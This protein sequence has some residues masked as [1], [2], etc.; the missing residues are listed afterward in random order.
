MNF[1]LVHHIL[2]GHSS[3][4]DYVVPSYLH[5][6]SD[7]DHWFLGLLTCMPTDWTLLLVG[8]HPAHPTH[9]SPVTFLSWGLTSLI[10]SLFASETV[11]GFSPSPRKTQIPWCGT[12]HHT[13]RD[14]APTYLAIFHQV[15]NP[16]TRTQ[17][18]VQK[19]P[20]VGMPWSSGNMPFCFTSWVWSI[21]F[22]LVPLFPRGDLQP[23]HKTHF[24]SCVVS[25]DFPRSQS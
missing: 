21:L 24:P 22:S 1:S 6:S 11:D 5:V 23:T 9:C 13:F 10:R 16:P 3:L 19:G 4:N 17:F 7:N 2:L 14:L 18:F 8:H 15:S 25:D 20:A 12:P